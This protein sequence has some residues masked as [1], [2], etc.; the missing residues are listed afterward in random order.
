[1]SAL[2]LLEYESIAQISQNT[3]AFYRHHLNFYAGI[4]GKS[5]I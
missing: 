1:M 4:F 2:K 3:N 5:L